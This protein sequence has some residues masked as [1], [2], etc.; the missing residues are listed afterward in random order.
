MQQ[1]GGDSISASISG[2]VSGQVA[3]GKD[4]RQRQQVGAA[5]GPVSDEELAS[6]R[7]EL[8]ALR[9]RID[10]APDVDDAARAAAR[11]RVDELEEAV[12]AQE[13]DLSTM[14]YVKKWFGRH[15]PTLAGA[16]ASVVVNP[17][18]GKLVAAAGDALSAEF[19][20]RFGVEEG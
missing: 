6:L 20:R 3:V 16:V 8:Q 1:P 18:V 17:I 7:A 11:E 19:R 9:A 13:P 12:T 14:E 2:G 15:L 5:A 10:S 4:I